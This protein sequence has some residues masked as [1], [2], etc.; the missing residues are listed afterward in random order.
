MRAK[1]RIRRRRPPYMP[2]CRS[3]LAPGQLQSLYK[4]A[5]AGRRR[6]GRFGREQFG[7]AHQ[8]EVGFQLAFWRRTYGR[9][10]LALQ[11]TLRIR[12]ELDVDWELACWRA[13]ALPRPDSPSRVAFIVPRAADINHSG[14]A[15]SVQKG[16]KSHSS[17]IGRLYVIVRIAENSSLPGASASRHRGGEPQRWFFLFGRDY[18]RR[19]PGRCGH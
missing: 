3:V 16:A 6:S 1:K 11:F 14:C 7:I 15:L 8:S 19:V 10:G 12:C 13:S 2:E 9:N 17:V 18:V 4:P 5:R